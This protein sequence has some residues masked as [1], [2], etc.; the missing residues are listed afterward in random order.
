MI[1]DAIFYGVKCDRCHKI[2]SD[3]NDIEYYSDA[4]YALEALDCA[5]WIERDNK[6]YCPNCYTIDNNDDDD[7]IIKKSFPLMIW[8]VKA[9]AETAMG[10]IGDNWYEED[11]GKLIIMKG[12]WKEKPT[13]DIIDAH[14][15]ILKSIIGHNNFSITQ[16]EAE[17]FRTNQFEIKIIM[18]NE[19]I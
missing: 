14:I 6:H 18:Q 13:F 9:Y 8:K 3:W 7:I 4:N 12:H 15:T 1:V 11:N 5:D 16:I 2:L 17:K 19:Q 10:Y